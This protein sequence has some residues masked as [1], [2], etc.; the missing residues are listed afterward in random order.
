[1]NNFL[2]RL[3]RKIGRYAIHNLMYYIIAIYVIGAMI[4]MI[5]PMIYYNYLALNFA[6]IGHGQIWRLITFILAPDTLG[7]AQG[8]N[9]FFFIINL[10]F[11]FYIGRNLENTWGAFRFN[12][13]YLSGIIFNIL[14]ALILYLITGDPTTGWYFGLNY[15]NESLLLAFCAMYPDEMVLFFFVIPLKMKYLGIFYGVMLAIQLLQAVSLVA[16]PY[17]VAML[18]G[19]LN[20]FLFFL[21]NRNY[22]RRPF[23][24][25]MNFGRTRRQDGNFRTVYGNG[26][27][28]NDR[29]GNAGTSRNR[30][31]AKHRCAICGRTEI[32][33]PEL[34]FRFCSKCE[35]NYE[36]C[37]EHLYKHQHIQKVKTDNGFGPDM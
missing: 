37:N 14:G 36:Y 32:S 11:Y 18:V 19:L 17:A 6:A 2:D 31:F 30:G 27:V 3:E 16:W 7:S 20:F 5:N 28:N 10:Y 26:N 24:M 22:R 12:M 8:M 23:N 4:G 35:G 15:V 29:S 34:E 1:M 33:N 9:I 13:Y 25:G 21:S